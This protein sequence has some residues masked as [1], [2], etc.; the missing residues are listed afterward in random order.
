[1]DYMPALY[2]LRDVLNTADLPAVLSRQD[3]NPPCVFVTLRGFDNW[4][5]CGNAEAALRLYVIVGDRSDEAALL[6]LSPHVAAVLAL[7]DANNLPV[8]AI[9]AEQVLASEGAAPYPAFR[10]DTHLS[11]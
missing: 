2:A 1:M 8:E 3:V 9:E 5:L 11:I 7:M 6:G 10:I 4:N